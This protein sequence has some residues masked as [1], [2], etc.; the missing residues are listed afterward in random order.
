M[1][2]DE[3]L[4]TDY[5]GDQSERETGQLIQSVLSGRD[6][7]IP[8]ISSFNDIPIEGRT[9]VFCDID[10]TVLHFPTKKEDLKGIRD[11]LSREFS[12]PALDKEMEYFDLMYE[13][14]KKPDHT[15]FEGFEC[16]LK[17]MEET[18]SQLIFLTARHNV[19]DEWT[20]Q[21][22]SQ[23]GINEKKYKVLY[24]NNEMSKG[25]FIRKQI[26]DCSIKIELWPKV[27]FI[28]DR[29]D[30]LKSV[31]STLPF[32]DCYMFRTRQKN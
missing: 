23:V 27:V 7:P 10:D 30:Q 21:H 22:L 32:I 14:L 24:T 15:D 1:S 13:G 2:T 6:R 28:D 11:D 17:K 12:G 29:E 9:L 31:K 4:T 20:R 26:T 18:G 3:A 19:D 16:M 8:V 25:Q 5:L